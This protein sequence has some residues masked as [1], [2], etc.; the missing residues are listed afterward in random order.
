MANKADRMRQALRRSNTR[1]LLSA[2]L[3][4]Q[5]VTMLLIAFQPGGV[6]A[7]ALVLC[8]LVEKAADG[9]LHFPYEAVHVD[10]MLQKAAA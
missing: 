8:G 10:F 6:D 4:F 7:Q 9:K 2:V 3:L 5:A 1:L